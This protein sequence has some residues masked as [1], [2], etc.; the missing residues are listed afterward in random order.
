[1]TVLH[2]LKTGAYPLPSVL[3]QQNYFK[4]EY[5]KYL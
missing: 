4:D 2:K 1:M 5:M 3:N